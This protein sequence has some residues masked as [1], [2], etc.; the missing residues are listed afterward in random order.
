MR[1]PLALEIGDERG[2][3]MA[4]GLVASVSGK[5]H[6]ECVERLLPDAQRAAVRG[7]AD[8]AGAGQAGYDAIER[9]V[10]GGGRRDL[11]ADQAALRAVADELAL[12]LD[13]L[14]GDAVTGEARQA[15]VGG[16]RN[17]AFLARRQ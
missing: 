8:R 13:G 9:R 5:I 14:A 2:T 12:V 15:Q 11:V 3:E 6:P 17:D 4:I 1:I 16:A 10:H 7:G